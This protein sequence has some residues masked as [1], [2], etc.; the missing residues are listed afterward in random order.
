MTLPTHIRNPRVLVF[1][2][3]V[4]GL[5][6][7]GAIRQHCDIDTIYASDNAAFPYGTKSEQTLIDRTKCVLEAIQKQVD[8]DII[9]IACNSAST[10]TLP[11]LRQ[12]FT[13]PVIGVVPAIKPAASLSQS[14]VIGLLATPGTVSRDYTLDLIE[15]FA[16]DCCIVPLGC[17][18][19]VYFA[20]EKLK[21]RSIDKSKLAQLMQPL[22]RDKNI[23]T[24]VLACT[25]FPL[26]LEELKAVLPHIQ[27]WVDSGDAIARRV[28]Y[29]IKE[30]GFEKGTQAIKGQSFFTRRDDSIEQ[31]QSALA[32]NQL[33]NVNIIELPFNN[34]DK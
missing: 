9:V 22:A 19:L 26:L 5:S 8:A 23:D 17:A 25:H 3:G 29:W 31:L 27:H 4:G 32:A 2:S 28:A 24:I 1:D 12:C 34:S 30:L 11:V 21:G 18:E 13:E 20:E 33:D 14:K 10:V 15:T 6:I 7:A 16:S